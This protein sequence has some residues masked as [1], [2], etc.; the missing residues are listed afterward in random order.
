MRET[1][2]AL[3][4]FWESLRLVAYKCP[5]GVWTN[6]YG[7]TGPDVKEGVV[8][9]K[10]YSEE[11]MRTDAEISIHITQK[12]CPLLEG[13]QISSISDFVYNLGG[14]R[15]AGSTLRRKLNKGDI[16][17][18]KKELMKWVHGGGRILPGLVKRRQAESNLL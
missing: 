15:L 10:E 2:Y 17:G 12:L 9:T 1:L 8:W 3:I 18:A 11:R 7:S 14:T 6:G 16:A 13:N 5:A 4:R